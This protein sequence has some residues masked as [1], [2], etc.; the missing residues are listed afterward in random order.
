MNNAFLSV[1]SYLINE[2]GRT[3]K[4]GAPSLVN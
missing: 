4:I 3:I 2:R 1:N